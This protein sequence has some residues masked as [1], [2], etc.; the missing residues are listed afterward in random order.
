MSQANKDPRNLLG[1]ARAVMICPRMFKAG[2][3]FGA[4]GGGCVML[5]RAANGTWSYPAFYGMGS[6]SFGLQ[7]G[8]QDA[9]SVMMI[10]TEKGLDAVMDDQFKIG[11]GASVAFAAWG[12]G[13]RA[14]PRRRSAPISSLYPDARPVRRDLA[15]RQHDGLADGRQRGLLRPAL[16]GAADRDRHAGAQSRRRPV[17]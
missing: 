10:L 4:E 17:A 14:P 2:F 3:I 7:A 15:G 9:Q 8:I 13:C 16:L 11:A 12:A 1:Q 5:A 6:G